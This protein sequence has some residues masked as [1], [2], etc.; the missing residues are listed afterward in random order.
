MNPSPDESALLFISYGREEDDPFI[1]RLCSQL[2]AEKFRVWRDKS[3][4][5]NRGVTFPAELI[6][7]IRE[8]DR[9]VF[10]VGP[11]SAHSA[12]CG[13]EWQYALEEGKPVHPILRLGTIE[14][15]PADLRLFDIRDF[16]LAEK[17]DPEF[18]RL[19]VQLREQALPAGK[20]IAVP[21]LPPYHSPNPEKLHLLRD[22]FLADRFKPGI[23]S[24]VHRILGLHGMSGAGK[25]LLA[26]A[27]AMDYQVRRAHGDGIFWIPLGPKPDLAVRQQNLAYLLEGRPI[28]F[29]DIQEGRLYLSAL[30]Q[31]KEILLILD[32]VWESEAIEAFDCLGPRCRMLITTQD[33]GL[34][35]HMIGQEFPVLLPSPLEARALLARCA[36]CGEDLLPPEADLILRKCEYLPLAVSI[37]GG[38]VAGGTAWADVWAGLQTPEAGFLETPYQ[39][40]F[41]PIVA[42]IRGLPDEQRRRFEELS[43]LF[44]ENAVPESV[45]AA[46][47]DH[48]G[49][50]NGARARDLIRTLANHHLITLQPAKLP[51][52]EPAI[53][54]HSLIR[55]CLERLQPDGI[56]FHA[57]AVEA[58][59][60][61]CGGCWRELSES[62]YWYRH[63]ASHMARAHKW[64]E[65]ADLA[66]GEDFQ[67]FQR[68][69]ERGEWLAGE[70]CL[71][72]LLT[73]LAPS[74]RNRSRLAALATQLSRL[75]HLRGDYAGARRLAK[76]ALRG[77]PIG[78][79][80]R[81]RLIAWQELGN[82]ALDEGHPGKASVYFLKKAIGALSRLGENGDEGSSALSGLAAAQRNRYAWRKALLAARGA[83]S[84][85][86]RS[87][88]RRGEIQ[89]LILIGATQKSMGRYEAAERSFQGALEM[90]AEQDDPLAI[91]QLLTQWGWM[92]F[93]QATLAETLPG[94]A[95]T[96]FKQ[97]SDR[98]ESV[99]SYALSADAL[100]GSAWCR[101]VE[102]KEN[103]ARED[104]SRARSLLRGARFPYIS[105][106]VRLGE[107]SLHFLTGPLDSI[108]P[109]F[110]ALI[111]DLSSRHA[112]L[113]LS[114]AYVGLGS[115]E[116]H[117]GHEDA[118]R[119]AWTNAESCARRVSPTKGAVV[120]AAID[121][122]RKDPRMPPR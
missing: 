98:A 75:R 2:E 13:S 34:I 77:M 58:A 84:L 27:L 17:Y 62:E 4:L 94:E 91:S 121:L 110:V 32:D 56:L 43:A 67:L 25:S 61:L 71:D 96:L 47:W 72:G 112:G 74:R 105:D 120:R 38:R 99:G 8:A 59:K 102:G 16:R 37:C 7:A 6:I 41:K 66:F 79:G 29:R 93:D 46:V 70:E 95:F 31:S 104:F 73:G 14:T 68:W 44:S 28:S 82:L 87:K 85:A 86:F 40:V 103:E 53:A 118:A 115:V 122:C 113:W 21:R 64:E 78:K 107:L 97:A 119:R 52:R 109:G 51:H 63:L 117:S 36:G 54:L 24:G 48:T 88:D 49:G 50:L 39:S 55:I 9:L 5:P 3:D 20:L 33:R 10:V 90:S 116:W 114:H 1:D 22:M 35:T 30:L 111:A 108:R 92:R 76:D 89:S 80:L 65:L 19:I 45:V 12:W 18:K 15:V 60:K 57:A 42:S 100:N 11:K 23:Q 106:G 81:P 83:R 26:S 69:T 101:L